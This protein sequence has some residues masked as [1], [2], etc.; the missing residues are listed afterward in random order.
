ML[1][2]LCGV[3]EK[4][5]VIVMHSDIS[6]LINLVFIRAYNLKNVANT[7]CLN[8]IHRIDSWQSDHRVLPKERAGTLPKSAE[9][10][11]WNPLHPAYTLTN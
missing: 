3:E 1:K 8:K 10:N 5:I 7:P 2:M 9:F 4:C 6:H 11:L